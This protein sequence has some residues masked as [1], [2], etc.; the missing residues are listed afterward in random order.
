MS[1]SGSIGVKVVCL[2]SARYLGILIDTPVKGGPKLFPPSFQSRRK[3]EK[4]P[5]DH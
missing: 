3:A 1:R 2:R 5:T 4:S